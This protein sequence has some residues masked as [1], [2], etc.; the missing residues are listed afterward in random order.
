[1]GLIRST[2]F[3]GL[4][5]LIA[6]PGPLKGCQKLGYGISAFLLAYLH[7]HF[8][9]E[10][11]SNAF[12]DVI[13]L[14]TA[15]SFGSAI[16]NLLFNLKRNVYSSLYYSEG[17]FYTVQKVVFGMLLLSAMLFFKK[18]P[19]IRFGVIVS[20]L[21]LSFNL[22]LYKNYDWV[23]M[24]MLT[25][26]TFFLMLS[27]LQAEVYQKP[28]YGILLLN[29]ISFL[30][31]LPTIMQLISFRSHPWTTPV[32]TEL[33]ADLK[34][35]NFPLIYVTPS[36]LHGWALDELPIRTDKD[37]P[38]RYILPYYDIETNPPTHELIS[39]DP[40]QLRTCPKN[41]LSQ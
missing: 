16:E 21:L 10:Q 9:H 32:P 38:I 6:L 4:I 33:R 3:F 2:W 5:G 11:V 36:L 20:I 18:S 22:I 25:P 34:K 27:M 8:F 31:I 37:E 35:L 23:E 12:T 28:V 1:L 17:W 40:V 41:I 26:M 15:G 29:S 14:A 24:R 19:L 13:G 30:L 39:G 7:Q